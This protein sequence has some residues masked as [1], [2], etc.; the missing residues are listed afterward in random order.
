V[1]VRQF[2]TA[3]FAMDIIMDGSPSSIIRVEYVEFTGV[4]V[5][6]SC[7][8]APLSLSDM[9]NAIMGH[10]HSTEPLEFEIFLECHIVQRHFHGCVSLFACLSRMIPFSP[11]FS[12]ASFCP[13]T[14]DP[15][16]LSALEVRVSC[17]AAPMN[18]APWS[19]SR[20]FGQ[21]QSKGCGGLYGRSECQ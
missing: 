16:S 7:T 1:T 20:R 8:A 10:W 5:R 13:K 9:H 11:A 12:T 14:F 15:A 4:Q 18:T 2:E 6:R 17:C 19:L 21:K 3:S